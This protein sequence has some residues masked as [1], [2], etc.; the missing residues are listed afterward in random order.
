M[1]VRIVTEP[2]KDN[3]KKQE[4]YHFDVFPAFLLFFTRTGIYRIGG[5][6]HRWGDFLFPEL[7]VH[8]LKIKLKGRDDIIIA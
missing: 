3:F 5:A 1:R 2:E 7:T 4:T 6:G 8:S